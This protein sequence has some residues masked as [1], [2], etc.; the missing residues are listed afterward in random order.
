MDQYGDEV[1]VLREEVSWSCVVESHMEWKYQRADG[2][3]IWIVKS[4]MLK[5]WQ[6]EESRIVGSRRMA[7]CLLQNI[8]PSIQLLTRKSIAFLGKMPTVGNGNSS[9]EAP[10]EVLIVSQ[11]LFSGGRPEGSKHNLKFQSAMWHHFKHFQSK[12]FFSLLPFFH[13]T[14]IILS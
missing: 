14:W 12:R 5:N 11:V 2:N 1:V 9:E 3:P 13:S 7:F 6:T 4:Q 10:K 8:F